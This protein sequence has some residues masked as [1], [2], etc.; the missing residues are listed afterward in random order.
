[1]NDKLSSLPRAAGKQGAEDGNVQPALQG[2]ECHLREGN[3]AAS[4]STTALT[5]A[6]TTTGRFFGPIV[7][8]KIGRV[9]GNN[10]ANALG[11][12]PLPLTLA[13]L[14]TVVSTSSSLG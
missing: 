10:T 5:Q 6:R 8:R 9:H 13:N 14:L 4:T 12:H 1:M 2:G 11:E 7:G 3:R